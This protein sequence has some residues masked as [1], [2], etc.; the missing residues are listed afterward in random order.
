MAATTCGPSLVVAVFH[1]TSYGADVTSSPI[2]TP[3]IVNWR[4]TTATSSVASAATI[5][6]PS[7]V[8]PSAGFVIVTSG[9]VVSLA[10]TT[11]TLAVRWLP[12]ASR[13][14]AVSTCAPFRTVLVFQVVSYGSAATSEPRLTPSIANCTPATPTASEATAPN[15]IVPVTAGSVEGVV[16][17]MS[18]GVVSFATA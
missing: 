9:G 15:A 7:T 12:A 17:D 5:T 2:L 11:V 18:G 10:T 3:S 13:A 8:A 6:V 4:P 14:V 1:C 16:S